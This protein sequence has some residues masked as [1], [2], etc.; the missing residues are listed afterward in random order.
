MQTYAEE[1]KTF[2][3]EAKTER[4]AVAEMVRMAEAK[5]FHAWKRDDILK[6]GDKIIG[7]TAI[8]ALCLPLSV[9]RTFPRVC[10]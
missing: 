5:G 3:D 2:L 10:A 8:R 9:K 4:D 7:S 1:Y 6:A